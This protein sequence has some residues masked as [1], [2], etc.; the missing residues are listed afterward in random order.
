M[1]ILGDAGAFA[2]QGF[3]LFQ[4]LQTLLEAAEGYDP[5]GRN[6]GQR[7]A[8]Q[9]S[10]PKPKRLPKKWSDDETQCCPGFVPD[11]FFVA[12]DDAEDVIAGGEAGNFGRAANAG[13]NPV[14]I[15]WFEAVT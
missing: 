7:E 10:N 5:D 1:N 4:Y 2:V 12:G 6:D 8:S 3:L 11:A 13:I 14:F 15:E 9:S